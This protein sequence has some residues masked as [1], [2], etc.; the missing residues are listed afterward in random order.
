MFENPNAT[1]IKICFRDGEGERKSCH[2][3]FFIVK[4][5]RNMYV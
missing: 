5:C 1:F 2:Y 4:F 3:I